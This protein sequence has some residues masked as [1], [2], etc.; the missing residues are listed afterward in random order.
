MGFQG[1]QVQIRVL[2]MKLT[3]T[4][5]YSEKSIFI[6]R[7]S[8]NRVSIKTEPDSDSQGFMIQPHTILQG[9]SAVLH[10]FKI[11]AL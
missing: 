8:T 7:Y 9:T 4:R 3:R 6:G 10:L 5:H 1:I 2:H 11:A